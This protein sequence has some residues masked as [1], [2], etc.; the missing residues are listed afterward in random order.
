M[1]PGC[2]KRENFNM[3]EELKDK[4]DDEE[5]AKEESCESARRSDSINEHVP[6]HMVEEGNLLDN[7]GDNVP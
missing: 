1:H 2:R 3:P 6:D 7:S 4:T 5:E